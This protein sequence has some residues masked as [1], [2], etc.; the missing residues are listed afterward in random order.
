MNKSDGQI[1]EQS[2]PRDDVEQKAE[3]RE[4]QEETK[5][6]PQLIDSNAELAEQPPKSKI[7]LKAN[8]TPDQK[9]DHLP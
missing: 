9:S 3:I 7:R 5:T 4:A 2:N 1:D 8:E 6:S